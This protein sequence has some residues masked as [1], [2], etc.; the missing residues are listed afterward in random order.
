MEMPEGWKKLCDEIP[1][2]EDRRTNEVI[3][4]NNDQWFLWNTADLIKEMAEALEK[5]QFALEVADLEAPV[6]VHNVLDKFKEWK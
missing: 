3:L 4:N 1:Y 6:E 5:A 2:I